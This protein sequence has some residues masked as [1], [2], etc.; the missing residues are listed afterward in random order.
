MKVSTSRKLMLIGSVILAVNGMLSGDV[1]VGGVGI[2]CL[3]ILS[4]TQEIID[5][6]DKS[7]QDR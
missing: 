4:T 7:N 3:V 2:I 1:I 6:I 5:A